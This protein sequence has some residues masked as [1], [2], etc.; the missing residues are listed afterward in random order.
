MT[1]EDGDEKESLGMAAGVA[2]RRRYS[3][4]ELTRNE[5]WSKC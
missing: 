1:H 4:K 3:H 2:G 5:L